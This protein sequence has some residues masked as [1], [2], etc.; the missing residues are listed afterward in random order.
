MDKVTR[1]FTRRQILVGGAAAVASLAV[2][3]V[4]RAQGIPDS[5]KKPGAPASELGNRSPFEKP[6]RTTTSPYAGIP[7]NSLTDLSYQ[8]GVIT[9]SDLHFQRNH[10]GVPAI[11]PAA[12]KLLIHG[13]VDRPTVFT[14]DD[15]KRLPQV[16]I[17]HFI[18]CSGNSSGHYA[19]LPLGATILQTHGLYSNSEWIGV[20]LSVIFREVG[21]PAG[22]SWFLAESYDGSAMSRSVPADKGWS[23]AMIAYGQNG[24]PIR[25]EQGYPARLLLPGWEGNI[26]VKWIRRIELSDHPFMTREETSKYT[27]PIPAI[28]KSRQF[29]MEW[30]AKSVIT[31]PSGGM[32]LPGAGFTEILGL[33]W[34]GRGKIDKVEVS[35]DGGKSWGLADIQGPVNSKAATR[36]RY[37]WVWDGGETTILSRCTDEIGY[38]QPTRNEILRARGVSNYHFNGIQAWKIGTDGK[39][40]NTYH[41]P[42]LAGF[43]APASLAANS[44]LSADCSKGTA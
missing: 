30:D 41:E 13:T 18:E 16:S 15:L 12:Y 22:A 35:T 39:V 21:V 17:Q 14:L 26:N 2:G 25:P 27:D 40:A 33:A 43:L 36:F 20:P 5:N 11:D 42:Q 23:D 38:V 8:M 24:E 19:G 37:P 4:A 32:T 29:T 3:K 31:R 7:Q 28:G 1:R 10:N 34:S 9:P 6:R 44:Q